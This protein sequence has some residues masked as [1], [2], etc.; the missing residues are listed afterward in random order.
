MRYQ[1]V[2][3]FAIFLSLFFIEYPPLFLAGYWS[4]GAFVHKVLSGVFLILNLVLADFARK[5]LGYVSGSPKAN[6][7]ETTVQVLANPSTNE[8]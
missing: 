4:W 6:D 2:L 3:F 8:T 1:L 7:K 5:R